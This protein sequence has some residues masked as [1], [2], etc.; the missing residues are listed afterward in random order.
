MNF[1]PSEAN[2][3]RRDIAQAE[4]QLNGLKER[5]AALVRACQQQG[6]RWFQITYEPIEHKGYH[7]AGDPPGTMGIDRQLPY[8]VPSS[9]TKQWSRTCERCGHKETTQRT[10]QEYASGKI[11]GTG[12]TVEVPDFNDGHWSDKMQFKKW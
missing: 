1:S 8:D 7:F 9:T 10:R 4:T 2:Q 6:H 11:P 12:G 5:L 3:L